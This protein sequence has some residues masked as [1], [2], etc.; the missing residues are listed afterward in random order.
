MRARTRVALTAWERVI[1]V[2]GLG[3]ALALLAAAAPA[4]GAG[5]QWEWWAGADRD[6]H[7]GQPVTVRCHFL[8]GDVQLFPEAGTRVEFRHPSGATFSFEM[9]EHAEPHWYERRHQYRVRI[10]FSG[11]IPASMPP[12]DYA[13]AFALV[14]HDQHGDPA[15]PF[16]CQAS[17]RF[18]VLESASPAT[19]SATGREPVKV[20]VG[21]TYE[22]A[23]TVLGGTSS[24]VGLEAETSL[25]LDDGDGVTYVARLAQETWVS[26]GEPATLRFEAAEIPG[27]MQPGAYVPTLHLVGVP[28]SPAPNSAVL[29]LTSHPVTVTV[30]NDAPSLGYYAN[31]IFPYR[32]VPDSVVVFE[33]RVLNLAKQNSALLDTSTTL[34]LDDGAGAIHAA[35]L[36]GPMR[37]GPK[38][39]ATLRFAAER[40][41]AAM[42]LGR[43]P[44]T[45]HLRGT[46][47][48]GAPYAQS[49]A[50]AYNK[51]S[52][53]EYVP[54]ALGI[55]GVP[56]SIS[57]DW[58]V[59]AEALG[60]RVTLVNPNQAD[61]TLDGRSILELPGMG[62]GASLSGPVYIEAGKQ[63]VAVFTTE[64]IAPTA[65]GPCTPRLTLVGDDFKGDPYECTIDLH[66]NVVTV[67]ANGQGLG[68][69]HDLP[70]HPARPSSQCAYPIDV[71][72]EN[73][74]GDAIELD[75]DTRI[76]VYHA[77]GAR[78][79]GALPE[80]VTIPPHSV[81]NLLFQSPY[82]SFAELPVG[83]YSPTLV[84]SGTRAGRPYS[85]ALEVAA[86]VS[87]KDTFGSVIGAGV[88]PDLLVASEGG[89]WLEDS[90]AGFGHETQILRIE[91]QEVTPDLVQMD[92]R[93]DL[94]ND[95]WI[96]GGENWA[97]MW[98]EGASR[99]RKPLFLTPGPAAEW[100][101]A[102]AVKL[103]AMAATP[104]ASGGGGVSGAVNT[105]FR[106][107]FDQSPSL[108]IDNVAASTPTLTVGEPFEVEV[109]VS[110]PKDYTIPMVHDDGE[111]TGLLFTGP[112][113]EDASAAFEV[114]TLTP[115]ATVEAQSTAVLRFEV[116]PTAQPVGGVIAIDP[117]VVSEAQFLEGDIPY[118]E[119]TRSATVFGSAQEPSVVAL[120]TGDDIPPE[121][122]FEIVGTLG[123]GGWYT[124]SVTVRLVA[125]D[126]VGGSGVEATYYRVTP[127][128]NWTPYAGAFTI[129]SEGEALVEAYSVDVAG[130]VEAPPQTLGLR[131]DTTPPALVVPADV[132]AE[133]SGVN[134]TSVDVGQ[135]SATDNLDPS[136]VVSDDAPALFPLGDTFVTWR[137]VDAAGNTTMAPQVVTVVNV[138][139]VV[140]VGPDVALDEGQSLKGE[141]SF[142]D[143]GG[144]S[145]GAE[146]DYDDG[147]ADP[148][149]TLSQPR[150]AFAHTFLDDGVCHVKAT[151]TDEHGAIGD[152]TLIATVANVA[153]TVGAILAPVEPIEVNAPIE[154][155]ATFTDPGA[156]DTHVARWAWGDGLTSPGTVDETEGSIDGRH[157]YA[158]PGVYTLTLNVF[159]DDRGE[160][161]SHFRYLV[162]Y[163]PS[164]GFVTGGGWIPS[165]KGAYAPDPALTG[166]A[167]FGFVAKYKK[168][169]NVPSGETEFQFRV[170][171]L[172]F[173]SLGY[174]W[175]VVSGPKAQFKGTGTINGGGD[176]GFLLTAIDGDRKEP[177]RADRFRI[178]IWD[179]GAEE[180]VYDNK[181]NE[182]EDGEA[183]TGI[184]GGSIVVHKAK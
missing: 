174:Q 1:G 37:I 183:S 30:P 75:T 62:H 48:T 39:Q 93:R 115:V 116:L 142:L 169:A 38:E 40:V 176:Y 89:T 121:T 152:D 170:A 165:P 109:H 33:F 35:A 162:V 60:F 100:G 12:G 63:V 181:M 18:A 82:V 79:A 16:E 105:R 128:G 87:V 157:S 34:V 4:A 145:W 68:E 83:D 136:P 9:G 91:L 70:I 139:P 98:S 22:F 155:S 122:A 84:L 49:Y 88:I 108:S 25:T 167:S 27:P 158:S 64:R 177:V 159:D 144:T 148:S 14:G 10:G 151:I 118:E 125:T 45:V 160:G 161:E 17:S 103:R 47:I 24:G 127:G 43:F 95:L 126:N 2:G 73:T 56:G 117:R 53:V 97:I 58:V 3:L 36:D 166:K 130:N 11:R 44:P 173:H 61:I 72:V 19:L 80:P 41:P 171:D 143:P 106:V 52:V 99:R 55:S 180:V 134:G 54:P 154:P 23:V 104:P 172:H 42:A 120:I 57:P 124:S 150:F 163:D 184:G 178:K 50:M 147:F 140:D 153:P 146:I 112:G 81:C 77:S 113:G 6:G 114:T 129:G 135:A 29:P 74:S 133:Q 182:A 110:N 28:S 51:V 76:E 123:E 31:G 71:Y 21:R 156:L 7:Q 141:C 15:G 164:G 119:A 13:M 8:T 59:Q 131:I 168:G 85:Q 20:M 175:L 138:I 107:I 26:R 32:V 111:A 179:R 90:M 101:K 102:Y 132:M 65:I 137:A 66:D 149:R 5:A 96:D 78:A 92:L 94:L 46:D 86:S 69:A 67:R